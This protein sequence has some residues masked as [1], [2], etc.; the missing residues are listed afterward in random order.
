M[1]GS[2]RVLT[3]CATAV[4]A[5]LC[6]AGVAASSALAN[7]TVTVVASGL[8]NP[9]GLAMGPGG[10]LYVA[11]AGHGGSEC[12]PPSAPGGSA[13]CIGFTSGISEIDTSG[14][15]HKVVSGLFSTAGPDGSAATGV[16]GI[17]L[18]GDGTVFAIETGAS[19]FIPDGPNPFLSPQTVAMARAQIGRLIETHPRTGAWSV[20][21]DVGHFDFQWSG[22]RPGLVPG[23]FP[24]ADPYAVFAT[25]G[26]KWVIDAASNTLD[27]VWPNGT[28][29]VVAFF[30][31]PPVSD[32]VPTCIDRGPDGAFYVGELTG[33]GNAPGASVVWRVVPG[34]DPVVWA[35]GLTAVT[36][37]GFGSNGQFYATEFS[38]LG[39]DNAAPNT[40]AVVRV[41]PH[42]TSPV[43]VASELSFPGGFAAGPNDA[44]YVSNW[45]VAPAFTGGGPTG[46][47]V[48]I[49]P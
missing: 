35:T 22:M 28:V 12:I 7:G 30:P 14:V 9:R 20:L 26:E 6:G 47:V 31:S 15:V 3:M 16:D 39:L 40:G 23:Q 32:S 29:S 2:R 44:I 25:P 36:G 19:D 45:S 41:P 42:S 17:S 27:E 18:L 46:Q 43:V 5:A 37:C 1:L 4:V 34:H 49:T 38:T 24:D 33:S 10:G 11:E 21:A 48:R 8:D 13:T